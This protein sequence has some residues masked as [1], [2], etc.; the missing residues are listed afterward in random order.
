MNGLYGRGSIYRSSRSGIEKNGLCSAFE[1]AAENRIDPLP[2]LSAL[3]LSRIWVIM[4]YDDISER[5]IV[6]CHA[7]HGRHDI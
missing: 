6:D 1:Q 4:L 2:Y 3:K 7:Q 5:Q